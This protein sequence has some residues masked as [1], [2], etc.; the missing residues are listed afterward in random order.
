MVATLGTAWRL[1]WIGSHDT[2]RISDDDV[3]ATRLAR[4]FLDGYVDVEGRVIRR[5]EGGDVVSG[6]R[7]TAC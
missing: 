2:G 1:K 5:D 6:G 3:A 7:R 4:E